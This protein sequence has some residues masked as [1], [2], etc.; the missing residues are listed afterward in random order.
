MME[1]TFQTALKNNAQPTIYN[2]FLQ[3]YA[4]SITLKHIHHT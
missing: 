2:G 4:M 1:L 3:S